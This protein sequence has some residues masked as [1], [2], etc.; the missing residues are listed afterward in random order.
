MNYSQFG[1][2]KTI[3]IKTIS[4][5]PNSTSNNKLRGLELT[6]N[7]QNGNDSANYKGGVMFLFVTKQ[8]QNINLFDSHCS[9]PRSSRRFY[10]LILTADGTT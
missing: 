5:N 9:L 3:D 2:M 6:S 10:E 1:S 8:L 4:P 7:T